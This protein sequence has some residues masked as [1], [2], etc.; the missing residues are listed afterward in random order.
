MH[1]VVGAYAGFFDMELE[2]W[3]LVGCCPCILCSLLWGTAGVWRWEDFLG[4]ELC[5]QLEQAGVLLED[6]LARVGF[7]GHG[8]GGRHLEKTV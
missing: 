7:F 5:G 4:W 8:Q 1:Q 6:R 2:N 3:L